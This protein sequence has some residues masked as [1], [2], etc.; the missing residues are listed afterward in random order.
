MFNK[1]LQDFF[2]RRRFM[3]NV[4]KLPDSPRER[5][6]QISQDLLFVRNVRRIHGEGNTRL[7]R[8]IHG[9]LLIVNDILLILN[10]FILI[11]IFN[12]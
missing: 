11:L 6:A 12:T 10:I 3:R 1:I 9:I 4:G 2:E 5:V 8:A 7:S